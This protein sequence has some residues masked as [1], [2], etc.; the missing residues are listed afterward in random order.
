MRFSACEL[1][2]PKRMCNRG[3]TRRDAPTPQAA[4]DRSALVLRTDPPQSG[5]RLPPATVWAPLQSFLG[6]LPALVAAS[7]SNTLRVSG[8]AHLSIAFALGTALPETGAVHV[9]VVDREGDLWRIDRSLKESINVDQHPG[10]G[11][12]PPAVFVDLVDAAP[13]NDAFTAHASPGRGEDRDDYCGLTLSY[14]FQRARDSSSR[15]AT[16]IRDVVR[17]RWSRHRCVVPS[18]PVPNALLDASS[19]RCACASP[20]GTATRAT[21]K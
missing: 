19:T 15:I 12:A 2:G 4:G 7:D 10:N 3:P 20:N 9:E 21:K 13:M 8:G 11:T 18:Y 6:N 16:T 5:D 17:G 14:V 1:S